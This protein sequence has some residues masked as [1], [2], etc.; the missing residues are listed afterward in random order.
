MPFV[1]EEIWEQLTD[2]PGTLIVARYP[3]G[4][5]R[6]RD[7][8]AEAAVEALRAIVTRVRT[9]RTERGAPPTGPVALTID[10]SSPD[11]TVLPALE[12]LAPL[13]SHLARL[14]ELRFAA[15]APGAFQDVVS[16]LSLGL[17]LPEGAAAGSGERIEKVLA[18]V[19]DEIAQ[20]SAKLQNGDYLSK[21]PPA[22]VEKARRRL[23]ELEEKRAA[24]GRS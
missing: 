18:G 22:V 6:S 5:P 23:H 4:D 11:R 15:P 13:L 17:L 19:A 21:A 3:Q 8:A 1:T 7:A 10:P 20:L 9:F 24:L 16:G 14:S 12:S 2:R